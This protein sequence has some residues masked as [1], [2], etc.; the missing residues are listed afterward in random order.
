MT[1]A[2]AFKKKH[3]CILAAALVLI[4]CLI[5]TTLSLFTDYVNQ[6]ISYTVANFAKDGYKLER[7]APDGYFTAGETITVELE[8]FSTEETGFDA[9]LT[10][11]AV[12]SSPD[13]NSLL[14][15]NTTKSKDAVLKLDG[16]EI[17]YTVQANGSISF[18]L[19]KVSVDASS[20]ISRDLTLEI[21]ASFAGTGEIS[22]SFDEAVVRPSGSSRDNVYSKEELNKEENL[23]FSVGVAWNISKDQ[24]TK[25]ILAY[26]SGTSGN[27][28]LEIIKNGKALNTNNSEMMD[29]TIV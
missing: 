26:L 22:F 21:P 14:W 17:P 6:T 10:M 8:E 28:D 13:I 12:W 20:S 27:Y 29:F 9:Q 15:G 25:D 4:G 3:L 2:T 23:G 11:S 16:A 24:S 1:M 7:T 19:P 18:S 5:V